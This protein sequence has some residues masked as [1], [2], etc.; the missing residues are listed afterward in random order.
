MIKQFLKWLL[1]K[2]WADWLYLQTY[3][4]YEPFKYRRFGRPIQMLESAKS[5]A[6]RQ[7]EGFFEKYCQ[8]LGLDIGYGGD[9][10]C[11]NCQGWDIEHGDAQYLQGL[12]AEHFDF[13]YSSHTLEH[14]VEEKVALQN[15]WHVL[16]TGGYLILYIPHRDLYEKKRTLPSKWNGDHKHFFLLDQDDPPDT[17][18]IVPLIESVLTDSEIIYAKVCNDGNT[19]TDPNLH[20][21][22]EYSIEVV[23]K[24]KSIDE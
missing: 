14:M 4:R 21:N 6:R 5:K 9:L 7:R 16:K 17:I 15:W 24:K 12:P 2:K 20:S 23:I 19:I 11:P 3:G 13:V 10:L 18:G 1:P 22:G 8:G